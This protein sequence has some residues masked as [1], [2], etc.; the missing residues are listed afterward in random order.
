MFLSARAS[1]VAGG[2]LLTFDRTLA[3]QSP[4]ARLVDD[5]VH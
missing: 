3:G 2:E 1:R 4:D 5:I